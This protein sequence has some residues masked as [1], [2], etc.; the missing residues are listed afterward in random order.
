M[1]VVT[2]CLFL[3]LTRQPGDLLVGV[4]SSG[5]NDVTGHFLRSRDT[6]LVLHDRFG[7]WSNWDPYLALGMPVHG[8]PQAGLLYP[9]NWLAFL[10]GAKRS[11]SWLMVAHLWLGGVGVWLLA[12][13]IGL[14]RTSAFVGAVSATGAPYLVAHMAEGH[15]AQLFTI[16]WVPWILLGFER[17]LDS[18]G[19]HWRMIPV[20]VALSFLAG[21]VQELYYLMLLLS[22]AVVMAAW[23]ERR[24]GNASNAKS[25]LLHW[26]LAG[27]F[28]IGLV[29]GDLL[30]VLLNSRQAVR[31]DRL[32]VAVAG[33]GLTPAH[34]KQLLNPF[35]LNPPEETASKYG[36]YWTK[37]FH[38]GIG[39][40]L[41]AAL[42]VVSQWK[43]PQTRRLFWM[44]AIAIVFAFGTAT[45]FF[46]VC[47]RVIPV[48]SSFRVPTRILFLCSFFVA[49]LAAIGVEVFCVR[50]SQTADG[51]LDAEE[52]DPSPAAPVSRGGLTL[53]AAVGVIA[54]AGIGYELWRHADRVLATSDPTSLRQ[55]TEVSQFLLAA[56]S[57]ETNE[58]GRIL[59][60]QNLYSDLE[61][62]IDGI[63][64][65][66]GY[67]PVPQ[68]RLAWAID[69][70]SD[71][72]DGQ[73]DFAGFHDL[74]L[75]TLNQS[76]AD[77]LG[78]RFVVTAR[79]Q[80]ALEGW[81][82]IGTETIPQLVQ[83]RGSRPGDPITFRIFEN[84]D[85]MP[86]AFV[87]GNVAECAD[88]ETQERIDQLETLNPRETVQLDR[89][90][91]PDVPRA[92]FK[93]AQIDEYKADRVM[94]PVELDAPG[95]L[96]LADLYHPGWSATVDRV[97]TEILPANLALRA[98]PLTAGSHVVE[99]QYKCPGQ[100]A[101]LTVTLA[102]LIALLISIAVARRP[103]TSHA[104]TS[105][106]ADV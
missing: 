78:A 24:T 33:D 71:L 30:P 44:L 106:P 17:F 58:P 27:G 55:S 29:C 95:Y 37:L 25:L 98:V 86:R 64:R 34:L 87:V 67:E 6:P 81:Q 26:M 88:H 97:P 21:H 36:F 84:L 32:P 38:F 49:I 16:A 93:A 13:H 43:R 18:A 22:G 73:L 10:L 65:V 85:V 48:I 12:R 57:G 28:S 31:S 63:P 79:R 5:Q 8:N 105:A 42:A 23:W 101:G 80:P 11:L 60:A 59:A 90:V 103:D 77:L 41:L 92:R 100:K 19:R 50:R 52:G 61:S 4:H 104:A 96:V 68:V 35:A 91:L 3:K 66:R 82:Q 69:A 75:A 72:P 20:C 1:A 99:F 54:A 62:F 89:D 9:P 2:A 51:V 74:D 15:V 94:I 76:V 83:V 47:Y 7:E 56:G 39:P 14:S 40:L 70:L 45:P 53:G 102:S 46:T